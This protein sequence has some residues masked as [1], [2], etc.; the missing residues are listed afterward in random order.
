MIK[1]INF[2]N[3]LGLPCDITVEIVNEDKKYVYAKFLENGHNIIIDRKKIKEI[4]E[5]Q[6]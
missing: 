2:I 3:K 6:K 4:A 1:R 5:P